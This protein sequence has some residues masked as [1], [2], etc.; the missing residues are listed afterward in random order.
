MFFKVGIIHEDF[1]WSFFV[2]KYLNSIRIHQGITYHYYKRIGS[3][4][5]SSP[6]IIV[7][8]SYYSIYEDIV[9]HLTKG[10]EAQELNCYV[11]GFCRYYLIYKA[12]IPEYKTLYATYL[13]K[14]KEHGCRTAIL[15]LR[16]SYVMGMVPF[17]LTFLEVLR[18]IR[19]KIA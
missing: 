9:H 13:Q 7:G 1:L 16:L 14:F 11:E 15:K 12:E 17:G 8:N 6:S 3:I 19:K 18:E 2:T 10:W 5:N 4:V